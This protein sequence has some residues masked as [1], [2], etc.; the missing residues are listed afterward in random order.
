MRCFLISLKL[1]AGSRA[2]GDTVVLMLWI[3]KLQVEIA[4]DF[5]AG[6]SHP[7]GDYLLNP[8]GL[9]GIYF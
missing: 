2:G 5:E 7:K 9:N 3:G 1:T 6:P 4:W 8:Q